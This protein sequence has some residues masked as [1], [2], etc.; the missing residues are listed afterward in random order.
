VYGYRLG[1]D[2]VFGAGTRAAV[3]NFKARAHLGGGS[4]VG[5]TT[6]QFLVGGAGGGGAYRLPL[7]RSAMP[8][9]EYDDPHHDYPAIDLPTYTGTTAYAIA[10]GTVVHVGGGCGYG[11]GVDGDFYLYCHLSQRA[12][13]NGA[14]VGAGEVIGLTGATGNVTGPHLHIEIRVNGGNRCPQPMLLAIYE[15][16]RVPSPQ[17]LPASGCFY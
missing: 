14:R 16:T 5:V 6:W 2:G 4:T 17:S 15:G 3:N 12:V 10:S 9:G 13:G 1:V 11:I 7:A 8:R